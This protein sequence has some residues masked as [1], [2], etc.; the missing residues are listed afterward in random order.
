MFR[1]EAVQL[2]PSLIFLW[3]RSTSRAG[4]LS[5]IVPEVVP[6]RNRTG[7]SFIFGTELRLQ[8]YTGLWGFNGGEVTEDVYKLCIIGGAGNGLESS[9]WESCPGPKFN[10]VSVVNCATCNT[11]SI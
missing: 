11:G 6:G 10:I 8:Q 7:S 3:I 1:L 5:D 4:E 9:F 2:R